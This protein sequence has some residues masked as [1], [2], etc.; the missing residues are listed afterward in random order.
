MKLPTPE[1]IERAASDFRRNEKEK[2]TEDPT[3]L[4]GIGSSFSAGANWHRGQVEP[5]LER[6][7]EHLLACSE[8]FNCVGCRDSARKALL[9]EEGT[10]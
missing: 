7:R 6:V 3:Y 5:L 4:F 10:K 2:Q 1:E 9:S 8:C